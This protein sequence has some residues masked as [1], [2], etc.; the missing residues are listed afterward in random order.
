MNFCKICDMESQGT[1]ASE[2][3]SLSELEFEWDLLANWSEEKLLDEIDLIGEMHPLLLA[4]FMEIGTESLSEEG[5]ELLLFLGVYVIHVF[6]QKRLISPQGLDSEVLESTQEAN[7]ELLELNAEHPE[8]FEQNVSLLLEIHEYRVLL[9]F[10]GEVLFDMEEAEEFTEES[11]WEIWIY[12]KI[13]MET[14]HS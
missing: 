14:F 7:E 13:V 9:G 12:L 5:Q 1:Q 2:L 11:L 8:K 4:F 3:F 6:R 10:L